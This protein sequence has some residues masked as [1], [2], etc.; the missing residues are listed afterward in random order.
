M[1]KDELAAREQ[2]RKQQADC[3]SRQAKQER[4]EG[5]VLGR[6]YPHQ[7]DGERADNPACESGWQGPLFARNPNQQANQRGADRQNQEFQPVR[8]DSALAQQGVCG[9]RAHKNQ[10]PGWQADQDVGEGG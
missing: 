2:K 8:C 4:V 5:G 7:Q 1:R 9:H 10:Q 6:I 3:Y